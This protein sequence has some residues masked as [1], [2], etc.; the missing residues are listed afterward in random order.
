MHTSGKAKRWLWGVTVSVI[1]LLVLAGFVPDSSHSLDSI[2]A[3]RGYLTVV[4]RNSP[5]TYY[6]SR[7]GLTGMEYELARSFARFLGVK[8]KFLVKD[9][10]NDVISAL[11]AG[12]GDL[13]AAGLIDTQSRA[14]SFL[15]GPAYQQVHQQ[16][17]CLRGAKQPRNVDQLHKFSIMVSANSSYEERLGDLKRQHPKLS[18]QV[19]Y[20]MDEEQILE[21]VATKQLNCTVVSS[22]IMAI[23]RRYF[24]ELIV[25][26]NLTQPDRLVWMLPGDADELHYA[27]KLWFDNYQK[28]GRLANLEQRFYGHIDMFDYV[29]TRTFTNRIGKEL[30]KFRKL[31]I[32][33]EEKHQVSWTLLAAQAYQES[34]W[35]VQAESPTGVRGI[36]MLTRV[37]ARELGVRNRL[38]PRQSVM[39]GAKYLAQLYR[40]LPADIVEPDRMWVAL[41]AYNVGLGHILDARQLARRE[42]LNP[43]RWSDLMQV[44]PLLSKKKYFSTLKHGY[45][46]GREPVLYVNN[47][48]DYRDILERHVQLKSAENF[49][50]SKR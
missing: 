40:R 35:R 50:K 10:V 43:N 16:V 11:H 32:Q 14:N 13:A 26:F 46:R 30:P 48:R 21:Q 24:P 2:V 36:M 17:V 37:T 27:L 33:A 9:S 34:H 41:A 8:T 7:D 39:G 6:E 38:D 18:W 22:T 5:T 28:T 42:K 31:F 3:D 4:T 29:D 20:D 49:P 25:A 44:L 23:N 19:T 45:A 15:V 47:I 1:G 12:E